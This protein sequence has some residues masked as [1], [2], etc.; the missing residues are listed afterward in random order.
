MNAYPLPDAGRIREPGPIDEVRKLREKGLDKTLADTY[1]CS[2]A[3]SSVPDPPLKSSKSSAVT[4][5][6]LANT[7]AGAH[8]IRP[9]IA[10][11][12]SFPVA[13]SR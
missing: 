8:S 11:Q 4:V 12:R 7:Q 5:H 2:D 3:L 6:A 13:L 1:P 10:A 9:S